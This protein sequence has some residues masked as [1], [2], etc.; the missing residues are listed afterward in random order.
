MLGKY[1][2]D[3]KEMLRK[4]SGDTWEMLRRCSGDARELLWRC[5]GDALIRTFLEPLRAFP[6]YPIGSYWELFTNL[7]GFF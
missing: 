3:P 2:E 5:S 7:E 6:E 4:C 1:L